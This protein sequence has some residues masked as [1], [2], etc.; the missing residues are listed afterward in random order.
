[1]NKA[2]YQDMLLQLSKPAA[3]IALTKNNFLKIRDTRIECGLPN[4]H[5]ADD[6]LSECVSMLP[7]KMA[8]EKCNDGR[9]CNKARRVYRSAFGSTIG[10][11]KK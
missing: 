2:L 4:L 6:Y 11:N 10:T 8:E 3:G 9:L 5:D 7:E 1:M